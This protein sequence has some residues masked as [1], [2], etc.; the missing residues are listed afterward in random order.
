MYLNIPI[1][2]INGGDISGGAIDESIRHALTK[3]AH[4]HLVHTKENADRIQRM[5]EDRNRI[6]VVG[7]LTLD[8]ILNKNLL[9]KTEVFNKY[10][11]IPNKKTFLVVQ[12][13]VTTLKDRGYSQMEEILSALEFLKEQTIITYPNCDAGGKRLINLI[14]KYNDKEYIHIFKNLP[15]ED[16]LSLMKSTDLMIGNSSSGI[17]EAPSFNIPVIN[18]GDRQQG[19]AKTENILDVAPEKTEILKAID[20]AFTNQDFLNKVKSCKNKFGD[21]KSAQRIIKILKQLII[22]KKLIQK[23]ITY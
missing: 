4:I 9:S 2:H 13:P 20:F 19:R 23:Q 15:H 21:G 8:I 17:I 1:A 18:I 11:L 5:G 6:F 14:E 10:N 3:I 7:A 12:H 16:Y 22:D